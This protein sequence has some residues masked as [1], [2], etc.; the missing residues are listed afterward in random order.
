MSASISGKM[1]FP[2]HF[3]LLRIPLFPG[4]A[5]GHTSPSC[6]LPRPAGEGVTRRFRGHFQVHAVRG[7]GEAGSAGR[8]PAGRL[9]GFPGPWEKLPT[10]PE[11]RSPLPIDSAAPEI[12]ARLRESRPVLVIAAPGA[13]KTTRLPLHLLE[14]GLLQSGQLLLLQ[15]RRV[16]ARSA[17]RR[18]ASELGEAPGQTAGY[19][20]RDESRVSSATRI[21][22]AT[23][24][25][26]TRRLLD[27]PFLTGV[28]TVFLDEFHERSL[29]TDLALAMLQE[30]RQTVRPDL[31]ILVGSATLDPDP[32]AAYLSSSGPPAAVVNVPGSL[33]PLTIHNETLPDRRPLDRQVASAV[34]RALDEVPSGDILVFLPGAREIRAVEA[35][36]AP[37][38]SGL[39]VDIHLLHGEL[40]A[41]TQDA[42][43]SPAPPGRRKVILSTNVAETSL[44]IEG[45]RA[46]VDSGFVRTARFDSRTGIDRLDTE[47]VSLASA[48]QRAGR[49]GRV[50]AGTVYRLF[51]KD[52]E[53]AL[54]PFD[55]PEIHRVDLA[56]AL[57][58][59]LTWAARPPEA[60]PWFSPPPASRIQL[61]VA[62][63]RG[64]GALKG[65][66]VTLSERGRRMARLPLHPRLAALLIDG[67][68]RG[69]LEKAA[70]IA[71]LLEERDVLFPRSGLARGRAAVHRS[72]S[73]VLLRA[74]LVEEFEKGQD[75]GGMLDPG[76]ARRVLRL[77][78]RFRADAERALGRASR[79]PASEDDLLGLTIAVYPD[80][81]ARQTGP[82]TFAVTGGLTARLAP[83]SSIGNEDLIVAVDIETGA[84]GSTIRLASAAPLALL[85]EIEGFEKGLERLT[86][87]RFD[88]ESERVVA[89]RQVRTPG[90]V[91]DSREIPVPQDEE[92]ER[93]LLEAALLAPE[94]ALGVDE[95]FRRL[96]ARIAFLGRVMPELA[97]VEPDL[98][99]LRGWL[100]GLVHGRKRFSELREVDLS[101]VLLETLPFAK[102][103][104]LDEYAPESLPVP[105]GRSIRIDYS[106][107]QPV[108]AVKLQELFGLKASPTVAA[109]RVKVLLHLLSPAGRPVQVTADLA[110]FWNNTY[111][112]VRKELRGR[113]PKHPW[114]EDPWNAPPMRGT[115]RSGR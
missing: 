46:V 31:G 63:L 84:S 111:P 75:S 36:L 24:G 70:L 109:G 102:K 41:S 82:G 76:T 66:S 48:R 27:D 80:R 67:H 83:E 74:G 78:D 93:V 5:R 51:S 73:D 12:L 23:E 91:L 6:S 87:R 90:L 60:F 105:T 14:G 53:R 98:E 64:L 10:V 40:S 94:K 114:P 43:L 58:T 85:E 19:V 28:G 100:P 68:G 42:A 104:A 72:R 101:S 96:A 59:V 17:A 69:H 3:Q 11:G 106:G 88:P 57:L 97:L 30:I 103:K 44:T 65:D 110:S 89:E 39:P 107:G 29:H 81:L 108:L 4:R 86:V 20:T 2:R 8:T 9:S 34:L 32:L 37:S 99:V 22:V 1:L 7:S 92:T 21:L 49:A 77:R 16:A 113:Y 35:A 33:F 13:G 45:V 115:T 71:V 38:L 15:P 55:E 95:P 79:R 52:D 61:A 56:S 26:L 112:V 18:L 62:L 54:R 50:A 47:R 25:V